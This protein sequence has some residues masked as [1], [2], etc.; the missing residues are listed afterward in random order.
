VLLLH[1]AAGHFRQ[2]ALKLMPRLTP[3]AWGS[4]TARLMRHH[5]DFAQT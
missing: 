4:I 1:E 3:R 2:D 5:H